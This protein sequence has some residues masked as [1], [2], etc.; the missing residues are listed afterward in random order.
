M[1]WH[2]SWKNIWRNRLRSLIIT[3]ALCLGLIGGIFYI[4][5][6]NGL[7]RQRVDQGIKTEV[8]DIQLH[9]PDFLIN[10]EITQTISGADLLV[11]SI[12]TMHT[13]AAAAARIRITC[14][15][16][17][18]TSGTG[19]NLYG[20]DPAGEKN[21]SD[22]HAKV[23]QGT[24]FES[25]ARNP[26]LIGEK[27]ARK[28]RVRLNSKIVLTFQD[29][30]NSIT[31]AAFK[32][33]GIYKTYNARFDEMNVY[34]LSSDLYPLT[35]LP[36]SR[37]HE[38]AITLS[39]RKQLA[40]TVNALRSRF[41]SQQV[42]SWKEISSELALIDSMATTK[43]FIFLVIILFALS[44]GIINTMLMA[45]M[46]RTREIGMLMA[47]GMKQRKVFFMILI[48]TVLLCLC[49]GFCGAV[50]AGIIVSITS[51]TGLNFSF[52][53]DSLEKFGVSTMVYPSLNIALYIQITIAVI[54]TGVLSAIYP[55]V[56]ALRLRPVEAIRKE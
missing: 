43:A 45:V 33:A 42:Q 5:L 49:G 6:S 15:A 13:V 47:I 41:P 25:S 23:I 9:N 3:A 54:V 20:I 35:G 44:F 26:V 19:V 24:F 46:E 50:I 38:I 52:A 21:V 1:L 11:A 18:A 36:Q 31:G 30:N 2:L 32:V 39:D 10:P 7:A 37:A 51:Y 29:V 34:V 28:L 27:L 22:L 55:A 16:A 14:M 4:G 40:P 56:K 17:S 12:D 8:S 48:E 53:A